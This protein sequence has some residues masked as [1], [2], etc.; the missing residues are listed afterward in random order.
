[1]KD[2]NHL[3]LPSFFQQFSHVNYVIVKLNDVFP[4]YYPGSDIDIFTTDIEKLTREILKL[5][6]RYITDETNFSVTEVTEKHL[7]VDYL[8]KGEIDFRFDIYG[9]IPSY[10]KLNI[11]EYLLYSIIDRRKEKTIAVNDK[12]CK[13][14]VPDTIDDL[15][16]R[17]YEYLEYY[18]ERPEKLKHLDYVYEKIKDW[19]EDKRDTFF[20]RLHMYT[21]MPEIRQDSRKS[22]FFNKY[23]SSIKFYYS[24]FKRHGF[25]GVIKKVLG[26]K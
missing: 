19:D 12:T 11:K 9:A 3:D 23:F 7:H 2:L 22:Y 21:S 10:S 1:M 25:T 26:V 16:I 24:K 20:N 6:K 5:G 18:E 13:V 15:L 4:D 8:H 14:F 17:Y